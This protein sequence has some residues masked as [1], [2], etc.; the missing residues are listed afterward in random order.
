VPA[1]GVGNRTDLPLPF[2]ALVIGAAFAGTVGYFALL[3]LL[4]TG[5]VERLIRRR[6]AR[7]TA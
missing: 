6:W 3:L 1:H 4:V 2:E 5:P 7:R